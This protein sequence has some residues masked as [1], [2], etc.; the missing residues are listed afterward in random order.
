[1]DGCQ[2]GVDGRKGNEEKMMPFYQEIK[3]VLKREGGYVNDPDDPGGETKYGISKRAHPDVD[4]SSLTPESAAE[5]YKDYYWLPAKVERLPQSLQAMYF[6]M[7][8]NQGQAKAVKTLQKACNGKRR[9][10]KIAVDGKIGPQT[11]KAADKLELERLR[12]YRIME[13]ARTVLRKPPLEKYYYG[14]F[15]RAMEV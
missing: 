4:I 3:H 6:D 5:I 14:W 7:V 11:I 10:E 15:K 1:M 13:Y 9:H 12:A 8:V 2:K